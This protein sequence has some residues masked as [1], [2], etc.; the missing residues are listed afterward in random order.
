MSTARHRMCCTLVDHNRE[1]FATSSFWQRSKKALKVA[2]GGLLTFCC[3]VSSL[4]TVRSFSKCRHK[5]ITTS[6][7]YELER[8]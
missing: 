8:Q 4:T 3:R 6:V 7:F 5:C 2:V 1:S